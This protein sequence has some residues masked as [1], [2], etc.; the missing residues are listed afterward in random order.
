MKRLILALLLVVLL[1]ASEKKE[2][3]AK[4]DSEDEPC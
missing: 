4:E 3:I 2:G 1:V